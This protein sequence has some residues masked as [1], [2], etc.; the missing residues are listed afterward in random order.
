[1]GVIETAHSAIQVAGSINK[2]RAVDFS[3]I[4]Q[5]GKKAAGNSAEILRHLYRQPIITAATVELWTKIS[6]RSGAQ[7]AID[8]L[9]ELD[10]LHLK[11]SS[12]VYAKSYEYR[13]YLKL[14]QRGQF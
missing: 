3:K 8:R 1:M 6:T 4:I 5:L 12:K 9:I 11:D 10:I 2:L 14:F 7:K 13:S